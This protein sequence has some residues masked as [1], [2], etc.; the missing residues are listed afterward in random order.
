[1]SPPRIRPSLLIAAAILLVLAAAAL[2]GP[3]ANRRSAAFRARAESY[4]WGEAGVLEQIA[5]TLR[6]AR[7]AEAEGPE[8]RR[9]A[10][11][12][13]AEAERLARLGAWHVKLEQKYVWAAEHPWAP[14]PP[15][16]PPPE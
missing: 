15:D 14:L 9:R 4:A 7:L 12:L 1:M 16:P 3:W 5:E 6:D 13:R 10:E 2:V 11:A 8:G